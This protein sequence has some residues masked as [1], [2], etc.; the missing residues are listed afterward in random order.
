MKIGSQQEFT[1]RAG[2]APPGSVTASSPGQIASLPA[3]GKLRLPGGPSRQRPVIPDVVEPV[4]WS[5]RSTSC[6]LWMGS[7]SRPWG[8]RGMRWNRRFVSRRARPLVAR[9]TR[10]GSK[11]PVPRRTR[12]R[13]LRGPRTGSN[14][15]SVSRRTWPLVVRETTIGPKR[16]LSVWLTVPQ[17]DSDVLP[18]APLESERVVGQLQSLPFPRQLE[19]IGADREVDGPL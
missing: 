6:S 1:T 17:L 18:A 4:C 15:L 19:V 11:R 10:I 14:G 3:A 16:R 12:S 13:S 7:G 2:L 9:G 8:G 5:V